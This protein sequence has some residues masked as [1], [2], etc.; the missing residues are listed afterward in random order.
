MPDDTPS[1]TAE[2]LENCGWR[3]VIKVQLKHDCRRYS[4]AFFSAAQSSADTARTQ[5]LLLLGD[6]TS[7]VLRGGSEHSAQ[8]FAPMSQSDGKRSAIPDDF[9]ESALDALQDFF[10]SVDDPELCARI[11]DLVWVRRRY[12]PAAQSALTTYMQS[13][14]TLE[15]EELRRVAIAQ[16]ERALRLSAMIGKTNRTYYADVI[17]RIVSM[18]AQSDLQDPRRPGHL[19]LLMQLLLEFGE[20]DAAAYVELTRRL[21]LANEQEQAWLQARML[22]ELTAQWYDLQNDETQAR[23][24]RKRM[25]LTLEYEADKAATDPYSNHATAAAYLADAIQMMR[26]HGEAVEADRLHG[27]LLEQQ[28]LSVGELVHASGSGIDLREVTDEA[29]NAIRGKALRDAILALA[30]MVPRIDE[31]E[32]RQAADE[33]AREI[34]FLSF[35]LPAVSNM[36][37]RQT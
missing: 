3:E 29:R 20:G 1:I 14:T 12:F 34:P 37:R 6:V 8:P 4:E 35:G 36:T 11:A 17:D 24:A 23:D 9:S 21:A 32:V 5:C 13:A 27:K 19:Q 26:R 31:R 18:L 2:D 10:P 22:W 15:G 30:T 25:A 33:I 16:L 28:A 7:M